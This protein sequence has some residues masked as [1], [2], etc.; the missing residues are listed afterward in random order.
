MP[1]TPEPL[2]FSFDQPYPQRVHANG[3]RKHHAHEQYDGA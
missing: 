1:F 2:T 3:H